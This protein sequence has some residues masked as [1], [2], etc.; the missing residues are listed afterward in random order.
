MIKLICDKCG[1]DCDC[2]AMDVLVR[3]IDNPTPVSFND[4]GEPK[5]TICNKTKRMLL[6]Q[7]CYREMGMPKVF[8][9]GL[10][11]HGAKR[12]LPSILPTPYP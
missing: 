10:V 7:S 5:M 2:H 11:F 1:K 8:F 9:K 12:V 3:V 6:C 4:T